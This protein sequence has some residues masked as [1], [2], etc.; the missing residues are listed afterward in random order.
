MIGTSY[1]VVVV[2]SSCQGARVVIIWLC[3]TGSWPLSLVSTLRFE[4][5]HSSY[6]FRTP[7]ES[8]A[9]AKLVEDR[10]QYFLFN[11]GH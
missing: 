10:W 9:A 3:Q 2:V 6:Q 8:T 11:F 4:F 5:H 7:L 1:F